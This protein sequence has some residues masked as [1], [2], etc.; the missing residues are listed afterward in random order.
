L[1]IATKN[2]PAL[3]VLFLSSYKNEDEQ[4]F[5]ILID[6]LKGKLI[7]E[8]INI[9][10]HFSFENNFVEHILTCADQLGVDLILLTP[11]IDITFKQYFIGP[12]AQRIIHQAKVAVLNIKRSS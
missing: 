6:E 11:S 10:T 8:H 3:K 7:G 5:S 4:F 12:N 1:S 2:H 9:S